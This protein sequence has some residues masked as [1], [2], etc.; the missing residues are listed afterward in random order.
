MRDRNEGG[1]HLA[2][3]RMLPMR[4]FQH[5]CGL[6]MRP[7][8]VQRDGIDIGVPRVI[9]REL[10]GAPQQIQCAGVLAPAQQGQT[11]GVIDIGM[12]GL[13]RHRLAQ[14]FLP[15][16]VRAARPVEIGE[17]DQCRHKRRIKPQR[18]AVFLL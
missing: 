16:R 7:V 14:Q 10:L 12:V 9:R 4:P 2:V 1:G 5:G 13:N 6:A 17:V 18:R 8:R 3:R 11:E 15:L